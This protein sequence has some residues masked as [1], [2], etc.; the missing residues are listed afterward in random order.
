MSDLKP[1]PGERNTYTKT[2]PAFE[3][4]SLEVKAKQVDEDDTIW[5]ESHIVLSSE[6]RGGEAT[7]IN[8]F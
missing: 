3:E 7:N 5:E 1:S 4:F 6:G 2:V 8:H